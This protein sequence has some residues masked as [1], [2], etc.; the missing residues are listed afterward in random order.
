VKCPPVSECIPDIIVTNRGSA[1][2]QSGT[3]L[4][5]LRHIAHGLL[6]PRLALALRADGWAAVAREVAA[7]FVWIKIEGKSWIETLVELY[8]NS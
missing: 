7:G 6:G 1:K 3:I 5:R 8:L 4:S 2:I